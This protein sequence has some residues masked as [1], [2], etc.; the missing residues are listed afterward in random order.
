MANIP[1]LQ[2]VWL[3]KNNISFVFGACIIVSSNFHLGNQSIDRQRVDNILS[4]LSQYGSE[5]TG[6][7]EGIIKRST[8][9]NLC[10]GFADVSFDLE[11]LCIE[12]DSDKSGREDR[13]T[14]RT[15]TPNDTKGFAREVKYCRLNDGHAEYK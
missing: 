11:P 8:S 4:S 5:E 15:G 7:F 14:R 3:P 13:G 10:K 1:H 9:L 2:P 6:H 12:A